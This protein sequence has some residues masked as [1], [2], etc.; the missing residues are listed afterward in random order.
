MSLPRDEDQRKRKPRVDRA[1]V[2]ASEDGSA[3]CIPDLP[4]RVSLVEAAQIY[5]AAGWYVGPTRL[6]KKSPGAILGEAW[7]TYTSRDPAT[8]EDWFTVDSRAK[9]LFLHVGKSGALVFDIDD[10]ESAPPAIVKACL[11]AQAVQVTRSPVVVASNGLVRGHYFF[12]MPPGRMIG[13]GQGSFGKEWGQVR[14]MNGIVIVAPSLHMEEN[15][16][17][18]WHKT[19]P[20]V[21]LPSSVISGLEDAKSLV[22][23]G[24]SREELA[25]WVSTRVKGKKNACGEVQRAYDQAESEIIAP[26]GKTSAHDVFNNAVFSLFCLDIEGHSGAVTAINNLSRVFIDTI[27]VGRTVGGS[28]ARIRGEREAKSEALRSL[29]GAA[30]MARGKVLAA[31]ELDSGAMVEPC[32]TGEDEVSVSEGWSEK[33]AGGPGRATG[34]DPL[35]YGLN[36]TGNA[37]A[38]LEYY[39]DDL[40]FVWDKDRNGCW[41]QWTGDSWTF[42]RGD[43]VNFLGRVISERLDKAARKKLRVLSNGGGGDG[44]SDGGSDSGSAVG[45]KAL[46]KAVGWAERSLDVSRLRNMFVAARRPEKHVSS[47]RFDATAEMGLGDG[48]VLDVNNGGAV[49]SVSRDDFLSMSTGIGFVEGARD[50]DWENFLSVFVVPEIREYLQRCIGASLLGVNRERMLCILWGGGTSGK[51]MFMKAISSALGDYAGDYKLSLFRETQDVERGEPAKLGLLPKRFIYASESSA[52]WYLHEDAIKSLTGDDTV[53]GRALYSNARVARVP[54]FVPWIATNTVPKIQNID[55][56][57]LRRLRVFPFK[58][59]IADGKNRAGVVEDAGIKDRFR[60]LGEG[61]SVGAL[62][63]VLAWIVEGLRGYLVGGL[64]EEPSVMRE[65][66]SAFA[67]RT[68]GVLAFMHYSYELSN[69][70]C[71]PK[72]EVWDEYCDWCMAE[73]LSY[74]VRKSR[75][76]FFEA[77]EANGYEF[78]RKRLNRSGNAQQVILNLR[79][80]SVK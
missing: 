42:Y 12:K 25:E 50:S 66:R 6:K 14:G 74:R 46:Y 56:P 8:I 18:V 7:P 77:L 71:V 63:G 27:S 13:N 38:L 78:G 75:S 54:K 51:S 23:S 16:R 65:E 76:E 58:E 43:E 10:P 80:R 39:G 45:S 34:I 72:A 5:A 47:G 32:W 20:L 31:P 48:S 59:S 30:A 61:G 68:S 17:Y 67:G 62:S 60:P 19:G 35:S 73:E 4:R 15:G 69:S 9:G 52:Q 53:G 40:V 79:R 70:S 3:T 21:G 11:R 2:D 24:E 36:D 37:D 57:T 49:R 22:K 33:K 29:Y 41:A 26:V 55:V 64:G 44:G 1:R 28:T